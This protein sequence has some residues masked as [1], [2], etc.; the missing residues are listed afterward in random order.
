[1]SLCE[2]LVF[3]CLPVM[4]SF[5]MEMSSAD[6]GYTPNKKYKTNPH[7]NDSMNGAEVKLDSADRL[8]TAFLTK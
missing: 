6:R 7:Y 5:D 3:L 2:Q 4:I 1:M 8:L